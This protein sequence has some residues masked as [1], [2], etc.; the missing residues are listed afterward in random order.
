MSIGRGW[1][2]EEIDV[3]EDVRMLAKNLLRE[4]LTEIFKI[5]QDN[6]L[7]R[8]GISEAKKGVCHGRE[9]EVDQRCNKT[10]WKTTP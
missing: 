7:R 3:F 6:R 4:K 1:H 10:S 2:N 5:V 9:K 8:D